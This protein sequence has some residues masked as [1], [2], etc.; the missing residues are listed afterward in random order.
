MGGTLGGS[1][2]RT[3]ILVVSVNTD[4]RLKSQTMF[5]SF[6]LVN[7]RVW[8]VIV[9]ISNFTQTREMTEDKKNLFLG[10]FFSFFNIFYRQDADFINCFNCSFTLC[11]LL[12][13]K[14]CNAFANRWF[15]HYLYN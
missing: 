9:R 11:S 2:G 4:F 12:F 3:P 13:Y 6:E 1:M 7:V 8:T 10:S 15:I 14:C 5:F